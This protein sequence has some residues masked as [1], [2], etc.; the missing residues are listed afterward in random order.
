[1]GLLDEFELVISVQVQIR[2]NFRV[3]A[4]VLTRVLFLYYEILRS[5]IFEME[6]MSILV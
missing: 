5:L 3:E 2:V 6:E 4:G 1:M